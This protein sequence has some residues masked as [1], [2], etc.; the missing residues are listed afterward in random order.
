MKNIKDILENMK[1]S[2]PDFDKTVEDHFWE[3]LGVMNPCGHTGFE[4]RPCEICGYPDPR[5]LISKL[6]ERIEELE[7]K[8]KRMNKLFTGY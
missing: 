5:K 8:V 6:N 2:D 1:K 4:S 3:L 7:T